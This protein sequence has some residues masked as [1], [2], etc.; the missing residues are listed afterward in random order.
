MLFKTPRFVWSEPRRARVRLA[1]ASFRHCWWPLLRAAALLVA[2]AAFGALG[3]PAL[4]GIPIRLDVGLFLILGMS[5]AG[6]LAL[7]FAVSLLPTSVRVYDDKLVIDTAT[8]S[9]TLPFSAVAFCELTREDLTGYQLSVLRI[10]TTDRSR[11][12]TVL[13]D[14][15]SQLLALRGILQ[16]RQIELHERRQGCETPPNPG[17]QRTRFARR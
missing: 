11:P 6:F 16:E 17:V 10:H 12:T 4:K 5:T 15:Q 2:I 3:S 7:G 13:W 8:Q 14:P 1:V 9:R